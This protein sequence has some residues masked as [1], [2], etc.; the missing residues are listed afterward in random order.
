[1]SAKK[2]LDN[3]IVFEGIDGAGKSTQ[4][5][6]IAKNLHDKHIK[7][8]TTFEPH[9]GII[10]T[11]IRNILHNDAENLQ[12]KYDPHMLSAILAQLFS[13]DR[14]EHIY[15]NDGILHQTTQA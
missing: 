9:K 3:F 13:A 2:I 14:H 6:Q 10:G 7:T 15:A 1:M 5:L 12:S 4:I 11:F 8:Y